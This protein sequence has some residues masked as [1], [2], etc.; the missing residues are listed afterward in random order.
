MVIPRFVQQALQGEP[1]TV[2]ADGQSQRCFCDVSD[3]VRAL[4]GLATHPDAPGRV[5]NIG[6]TEEVSMLALAERVRALTGSSSPIV[7]IPY[8]QAYGPGF[9][10]MRRRVPD[11]RRI[12]HLLGWQPENNLDAILQ[13]IIQ[14][15]Q[16]QEAQI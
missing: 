11:I 10:D 14:Y 2:Y 13:R 12:H 9:E 6:A 5:Y 15:F 16:V 4:I 1:L 3:V 7:H 8:A